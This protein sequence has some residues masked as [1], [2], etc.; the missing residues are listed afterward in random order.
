MKGFVIFLKGYKIFNHHP[1][2]NEEIESLLTIGR[3]IH[4]WKRMNHRFILFIQAAVVTFVVR[5]ANLYSQVLAAQKEP[6]A[7]TL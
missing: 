5:V 4:L 3:Q 1:F 2:R 7:V 6:S